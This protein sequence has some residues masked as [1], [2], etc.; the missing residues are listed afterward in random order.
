MKTQF[1]L[2]L[3]IVFA[4]CNRNQKKYYSENTLLTNEKKFRVKEV[5][6]ANKYTYFKV[7]ENSN[8]RWVAVTKT[9]ANVGDVYYY[10]EAMQ[11]NNFHSRDLDKTFDV[12]FFINQI[13]KMPFSESNAGGMP[14]HSGKVQTKQRG[15]LSID[16]EED[17]LTIAQIFANSSAY[18]QKEVKIRGKVVKVNKDVMGKNWIHIQ[19]GT[20]T[21]DS[22]DL[23]ITS[24][25]LPSV[26]DEV[27]FKGIVSIDRDFGSGYYYDVIL[28]D[29]E[30]MNQP[31]GPGTAL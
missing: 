3:I 15:N 9:D 27:I 13:S 11:M 31:D 25:D 14:P 1:F 4:S 8:E 17:E 29:A 22:Y 20:K 5:V 7:D 6:Q 30:L 23:T 2:I 18:A 28:E 12:I 26:N 16:K 10:D 21:G 24:Q 19:D